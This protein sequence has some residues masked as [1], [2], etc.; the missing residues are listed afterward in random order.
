MIAH[1]A[2]S[3][4]AQRELVH[5]PSYLFGSCERGNSTEADRRAADMRERAA[6]LVEKGGV[7]RMSRP[8]SIN[9]QIAEAI[10]ALPLEASDD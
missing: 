7:Y 8:M 6:K 2:L 9:K 4:T 5:T 3:D 1:A 10:R